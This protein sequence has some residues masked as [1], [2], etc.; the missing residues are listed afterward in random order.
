MGM[1]QSPLCSP[2]VPAGG[3]RDCHRAQGHSKHQHRDPIPWLTPSPSWGRALGTARAGH[4]GREPLGGTCQECCLAQIHSSSRDP[5]FHLL[6]VRV[7]SEKLPAVPGNPANSP[8]SSWPSDPLPGDPTAPRR[9]QQQLWGILAGIGDSR[10]STL[11]VLELPGQHHPAGMQRGQ[12]HWQG[13]A[14][15]RLQES[16]DTAGGC[17]VPSRRCRG[18][19]RCGRG[20]H[21]R[22]GAARGGRKGLRRC[23]SGSESREFSC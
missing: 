4:G 23:R 16:R 21:S 15:E 17:R 13:G 19:S 8:N 5:N 9:C 2:E 6:Q 12:E 7:G 20:G 18:Q 11:Q 14:T 1:C 10:D 3:T 22:S